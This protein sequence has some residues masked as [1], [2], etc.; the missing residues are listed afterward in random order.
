MKTPFKKPPRIQRGFALIA[1]ISVM[2]LLVMIALAMLSLST[3]ELRSSRHDNAQAEAQANARMGL[4]LALGRLQSS[5][6]PD[7]RATANASILDTDPSTLDIDGVSHSHWLGAY[8]TINPSSP[9]DGLLS[10]RSLRD[11]SLENLQWL[12]SSANSNPDPTVALSGDS[13]TLGQFINDASVTIPNNSGI[14]GLSPALLSK[15]QAGLVKVL[16]NSGRYAWWVGDESMKARVDTLASPDGSDVLDGSE[17]DATAQKR[18]NYQII[19]GNNFSDL[20]PGYKDSAENL[21]KLITHG[22]LDLLGQDA[23]WSS[24][25]KLNQDKFT[26]YSYSLPVDVANGRLKQDLTAYF[27]GSYTGHDQRS[28]IDP[29]F[30]ITAGKTPSFDLLKQWANMVEDH[31][32]PQ[33][34][35]ASDSNSSTPT[36]GL[37]PLITQGAVAMQQS[38]KILSPT[39]LHPVFM[40]QPQFQ[41]WNPHNVPLAAKD[42]IIQIG[43]Q[44]RWWMLANGTRNTDVVNFG[45]P[46]PEW[47]SW[48][49]STGQDPLPP[50]LPADNEN[51]NYQNN[52]RFFTFVIK[53]QAFQPGESLIFYAKPPASGHISGVAYNMNNDTDTEILNNYSNDAD[54]NLLVNEGNLD[55]FFYFVH[56]ATGTAS[57]STQTKMP[58][59]I[60]TESNFRSWEDGSGVTDREDLEM[61]LN[62]YSVDDGKASLLHAMKKPQ[63]NERFGNWK[64]ET[65]PLRRYQN[66]E[67]FASETYDAKSALINF[68]SSMLAS[69]FDIFQG[70]SNMNLPPKSGQPHSVLGQWNIRNQESFTTSSAWA[71]GSVEAS[72][73]L[74]TFSFRDVNTFKNTWEATDN[75]YGNLSSDRLG[76]WHQSQVQGMA[77]PFFDYPTSQYGPLSLGSFQHANLSVYS[78]QPTYAF[79]NAQAPPRFDRS[80][81][82]SGS[83]SDLYDV[84]YMLN[85]STWDSYY[86]STIP[87]NDVTLE[88]GMRL[89]NS[90]QFLTS[91]TS[92]RD[93]DTSQLTHEDGFELSAANVLIHG[94]FNV[95]STSVV[96]W[97][98][99]LSG[100]MGQSVETL[101]SNTD[102][103]VETAAAMGRF[104]AP[105][106]EE[107]AS[108]TNERNSTQFTDPNSWAATRTL[109]AEEIDTLATRLVEEVKRRGPFLSMA[110]F[111]NR[112]LEPDSSVTDDER[113]YQEVL[114]TLQ[115]VINKA[116]AEDQSINYHY[117]SNQG[118]G[119][120]IMSIKPVDDWN[121][122]TVSE[123]AQEAM[124]GYPISTI[125]RQG[126]LIHNYAP[127][128][129]SQADV[130]TKIGPSITVR[131]D[132]YVIR[133]YGDS[134]DPRTGKIA[135][136]AW[137]EAVVQRVAAPV[138]WDGSND[139]LVQPQA[140]EET[141]FGRHFKIV[142]F[143]WLSKEDVMPFANDAAI[144]K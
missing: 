13:V 114:G 103:N 133:S 68:G 99:F 21:F 132:T 32:Q 64:R 121:S 25:S 45:G 87:Q 115:A 73:W 41:L 38:Y 134:I 141:G 1:T 53:N 92:E 108:V 62:L 79:G 144:T 136:R 29:R 119:S 67:I 118:N 139:Q 123:A 86:L 101:H 54:L 2:V 71:G 18:N 10:P 81:K 96:A 59:Q 43:Y 89:P 6:G 88:K 130:L 3:I 126:G 90:R 8:P 78:W 94:G 137:C 47:R 113:V 125:N 4:Q 85:A 30:S 40:F 42:Y 106:L 76:G 65:Y 11:W 135:A 33:A 46:N 105:L 102:S 138:G 60:R 117:Y 70:G 9:D 127:N 61:H 111:V 37:H 109:N 57:A 12:V 24:W 34:V 22:E 116:P 72:S 58:S 56:P 104:L 95:N 75:L 14:D 26:P 23:S 143:R 128:F 35:V 107:P 17:V 50:H 7:A 91:V 112:R 124:F 129:L 15:A 140:P 48:S 63:K 16:D 20:L 39:T 28:M 122:F 44:F 98:A 80:Q 36:H 19:Q 110:D 131:G 84:S 55:E 82:Q 142:S 93:L 66:G 120:P 97:K 52:K 5:L 83:Q 31:K 100:A 77:Y 27:K 51:I 74:N 49:V 69:N